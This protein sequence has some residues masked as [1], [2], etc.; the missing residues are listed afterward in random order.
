MQNND[1]NSPGTGKKRENPFSVPEN[2]FESFPER[3][4]QRLH[5]DKPEVSTPWERFLMVVKPQL[6]AAAV[7]AVLFIAGY[8]GLRNFVIQQD[9]LL[10]NEEITGYIELYQDD[11]S[12]YYF[13]SM[14]DNDLYPEEFYLDQSMYP[15]D[16]D[17]Y[18]DYLYNTD[19]DIE[20]IITEF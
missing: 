17:I 5:E 6:A 18:V 15:A 20:M 19:I 13:L 7:I 3:L 9:M 2:Y 14:L 10:T 11:F 8:L 16:P 12:D 4:R 1:I